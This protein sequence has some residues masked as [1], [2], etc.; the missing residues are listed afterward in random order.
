MNIDNTTQKVSDELHPSVRPQDDLF[1]YVNGT[2]IDATVIPADQASTG[3][4]M[5]LRNQAEE[6]VR[7]IITELAAAGS[8]DPD[9]AK[10]GDLYN[11]FMNESVINGLGAIPLAPEYEILDNAHTKQGLEM[12]IATFY[13]TGV[14]GPFGIGTN[15]DRNNPDQYIPWAYQSGIGLPDE[16]FYRSEEYA[17]ILEAYKQFI[18][19]LYSLAT[20]VND[21]DAKEAAAK[22]L[23]VE[24]AIASHHFTVVESRDAEL[25]NNVMSYD[26]FAELSGEFDMKAVLTAL[27]MTAENAPEILC[28]TPRSFTGLGEVWTT[29]DVDTLRTYIRWHLILARAPYLSEDIVTAH[30]AF[31]GTMLSGQEAQRDRWKRAVVL[32][33]DGLGE[34]VGK[35]YVSKHFPPENKA[36][37]EQL[38]DDLLA[39]YHDSISTLDW[40]T[41]ETRERALAKLATFTPKIGYPVTWRDYS[42]LEISADD[43]LANIRAIAKFEFDEEINKLGKPVDRDEWHMTP[44]TV[45][46]YYNP[47]MNEIVFPAA[48]LQPP[49][50]DADADPAWNYGGIGAV[51]GHEIGHGFDDQGS[52]YD[53]S[54]RLNNWWTD[55]DREEFNKRTKT[56][57]DQYSTYVPAQFDADSPHHVNGELTLGE[58]IGDLGGITIGLK[59]YEIAC[60]RAGF[61]SATEAPVLAGF[62]GIQRVLL[63]YARIWQ[64]KRRDELMIQ[65]VATDPHSPSEFRCNGVVKNVDAFA[66][67]FDVKPGD[68]LYLAPEDRVRIW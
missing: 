46:A 39:A 1:R 23:D 2:W 40:M 51:I 24:T 10:I 5:D 4:F 32:V 65:R 33:N 35:V 56:L 15:A 62:T 57:V 63:S 59:A 45:N 52:K 21:V 41:D 17:E 54:G 43:L 18:P 42:E 29:F 34:A 11:S 61:A 36:K 20:G 44:Q 38:V 22:I 14:G 7:T 13:A 12:A 28:M 8:N 37:M 25:T 27:G 68:E 47:I 64:E 6:D 3:S 30:F 58:N 60:R 66:Q 16:A 26:E 19:T 53:G 31:Y 55:A 50:F 49:F 48:I 9:A 67:A